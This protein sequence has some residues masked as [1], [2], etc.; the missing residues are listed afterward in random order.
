M[1]DYLTVSPPWSELST[2][3][4]FEVGT[5]C[6][7][8]RAPSSAADS[9]CVTDAADFPGPVLLI[10]NTLSYAYFP[11]VHARAATARNAENMTEG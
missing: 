1:A 10:P 8:R 3:A 7:G 11:N 4:R 5:T 6:L 2:A 9:G